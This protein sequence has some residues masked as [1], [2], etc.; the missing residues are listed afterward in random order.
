M[1]HAFIFFLVSPAHFCARTVEPHRRYVR[2][3]GG[4]PGSEEGEAGGMANSNPCSSQE[5]LLFPSPLPPLLGGQVFGGNDMKPGFL[6]HY[7]P[8]IPNKLYF[9]L[10]Q[11]FAVQFIYSNTIHRDHRAINLCFK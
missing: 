1:E 5:K 8:A 4:C 10:K 7:F 3:M 11:Q 2:R 6:L 9:N